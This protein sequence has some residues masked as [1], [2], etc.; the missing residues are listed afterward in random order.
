MVL[1][2]R[3]MAAPVPSVGGLGIW[4]GWRRLAWICGAA[5]RGGDD[6]Q[7]VSI[8]ALSAIHGLF[9]DTLYLPDQDRVLAL[10]LGP[11]AFVPTGRAVAALSPGQG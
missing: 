3:S 8:N 6:A 4:H 5:E 11:G 9:H 7:A 1:D 10:Q 2:Q